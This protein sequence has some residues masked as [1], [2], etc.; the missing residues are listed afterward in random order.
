M[1][2]VLPLWCLC[3]LMILCPLAVAQPAAGEK[4]EAVRLPELP[5]RAAHAALSPDGRQVAVWEGSGTRLTRERTGPTPLAVVDLRER[6]VTQAKEFPASYLDVSLGE[7]AMVVE[8]GGVDASLEVL[9]P[10]TLERQAV[11]PDIGRSPHAHTDIVDGMLLLRRRGEGTHDE[12][13]TQRF[14]LPDLEPAPWREEGWDA[15]R[16]PPLVDE[17]LGLALP[18]RVEV[19]GVRW[20]FYLFDASLERVLFIVG[21][22]GFDVPRSA[23]LPRLGQPLPLRRERLPE[24]A[25]GRPVSSH[26]ALQVSLDGQA[27]RVLRDT[28]ASVGVLLERSRA[29]PAP[30]GKGLVQSNRLILIVRDLVTGEERHR[31]LLLE[32]TLPT[33]QSFGSGDGDVLLLEAGP[34]LVLVADRRVVDYELPERVR[35][36]LKVPLHFPRRQPQLVI[37]GTDE[38]TLEMKAVGGEGGAGGER[39]VRYS[40]HQGVPGME[41]DF[42]T[43][44]LTVRPGEMHDAG[45]E[46]VVRFLMS[47]H[48]RQRDGMGDADAVAGLVEELRNRLPPPLRERVTGAPVLVPA[49]VSAMEAGAGGG[50][51]GE[52]AK[53]DFWLMLDVPLEAVRA[54]AARGG[55]GGVTPPG[56]EDEW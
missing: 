44:T 12:W 4:L 14:R 20:G 17:K 28:P 22:E 49:G 8:L 36:A 45:A 11:M 27:N 51:G 15:S 35:E 1:P 43:G 56:L 13:G 48:P 25:W 9:N 7:E 55:E 42:D 29:E 54:K 18:P 32:Q 5:L 6:S 21:Y 3:L 52:G 31:A 34:R 16:W 26:P 53:L 2:R 10:A 38:A 40:L 37:S 46:A 30:G 23:R 19:D 41:I 47:M 50:E 39:G 24:L 33:D